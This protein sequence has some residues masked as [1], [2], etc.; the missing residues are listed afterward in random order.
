M[1]AERLD[2]GAHRE[3]VAAEGGAVVA[4]AEHARRG[5]GGHAG[6]DRHAVSQPLGERHH[7]G[8][9]AGPLVREPVAGAADAA[10]HFVEHQQPVVLVAE[11]PQRLEVV[12]IGH[13]DAA[14]ALD[15]LD[16]TATHAML[17]SA[18]RFTAS[19]SSNGTRTKPGRSGSNPGLPC[20]CR[21]RTASRSCGRGTLSP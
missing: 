8:L 5:P 2:A 17:F 1:I 16:Q 4:R 20:G 9:D 19:R 21:W 13:I 10:L 11:L 12:D 15:Q 3:R 14:F 6:A 18:A 7:V